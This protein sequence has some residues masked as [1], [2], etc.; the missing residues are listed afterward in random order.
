MRSL[1]FLCNTSLLRVGTLRYTTPHLITFHA[2][3][4][5]WSFGSS[6]S[7]QIQDDIIKDAENLKEQALKYLNTQLKMQEAF[8]NFELS[9]INKDLVQTNYNKIQFDLEVK[10]DDQKGVVKIYGDTDENGVY[11]E[12]IIVY[13]DGK[14][15]LTNQFPREGNE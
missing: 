11:L 5:S 8:P 12:N 4:Y 14:V 15:V 2:R 3:N 6:I 13:K 1:K 10:S 7:K 9:E